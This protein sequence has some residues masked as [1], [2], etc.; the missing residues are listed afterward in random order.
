MQV[1]L[2]WNTYQKVL[3]NLGSTN[4]DRPMFF[5]KDDV[6]IL[7]YVDDCVV[8]SKYGKNIADTMVEL[9]TKYKITYERSME[10]YLGIQLEHTTN[11]IRISQP[12]LIE[13]IIDEIPGTKNVNPVNYP[14][15]LSLVLTK[16]EHGPERIEK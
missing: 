2:G 10:E 5:I 11:S 9:R 13:R 1:E 4:K 14:A 12:L 6:V 15:L 7:I 3:L 16:D 8:I